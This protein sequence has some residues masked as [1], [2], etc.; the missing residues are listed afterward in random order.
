MSLFGTIAIVSLF[1]LG[2]REITDQ[3]R[4]GFPIRL[5]FLRKWMPFWIARPLIACCP[6]LASFWG[7]AIYWTIWCFQSDV[8]V[9][10]ISQLEV[11]FELKE[12]FRWVAVCMSASFVNAFFWLI[13]SWLYGIVTDWA[14]LRELKEKQKRQQQGNF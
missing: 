6:C 5:F 10:S 7:T 8:N 13:R 9:L 11:A 3:G 4:I 14:E 12:L 1:C 2:L